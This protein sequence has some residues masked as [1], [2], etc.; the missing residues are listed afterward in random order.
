MA[1]TGAKAVYSGGVGDTILAADS[2]SLFVSSGNDVVRIDV[3][4]GA[5]LARYSL[6][7]RAGA[8]D[9]SADG[10]H[11]VAVEPDGGNTF[12]YI[13]LA[14]GSVYQNVLPSSGEPPTRCVT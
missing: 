10:K 6:G 2:A 1:I 9:V 8:L 3:V 5:E 7:T 4:T 13:D 11:L 12:A 14:Q